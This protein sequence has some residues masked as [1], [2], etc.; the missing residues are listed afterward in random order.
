MFNSLKVMFSSLSKELCLI[1]TIN[2]SKKQFRRVC[3]YCIVQIVCM[4]G[5]DTES[6]SQ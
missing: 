2:C 4:L 1:I 6:M 3:N 5:P